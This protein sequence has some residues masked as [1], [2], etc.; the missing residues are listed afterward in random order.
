MPQILLISSVFLMSSLSIFVTFYNRK[1]ASR[2]GA[3]AL[4]NYIYLITVF[5]GWGL[6]FL[7]E[8]YIEWK[9]LP[10]SILFGV[11]F[12]V[13]QI[14]FISAMKTGSVTITSLINQL[15][16]IA[17]TV[18]G[19]FFWGEKITLCVGI[20]LLLVVIALYLCICTGTERNSEGNRCFG[21]WLIFSAMVFIGNAGCSIVQRTE[22]MHFNGQYGEMLM[23]F[24][25]GIAC[26]FYTSVFLKSDKTDFRTIIRSSVGFPILGGVCNVLL[27]L[28]VVMLATSALSPSL[29]YPVLSIGAIAATSVFSALVFKEKLL[30]RQWIG[31]AVGACAVVLLSL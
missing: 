17:T 28:F 23:F 27:N 20:G 9:V 2:K 4:Y 8:P 26:V 16:L 3:S 10:Y 30:S 22:Q 12:T 31:I 19:F 15:S 18:W 25:S 24:A 1:N 7:R 11:F 13:C 29:I 5:I 6:L 21:K 14:G